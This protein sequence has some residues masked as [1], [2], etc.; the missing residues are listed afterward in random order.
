LR[1]G[2]CA[3]FTIHRSSA[4]CAPGRCWSLPTRT[5]LGRR[6]S[7]G[8]WQWWWTAGGGISRGHR[9]ARIWHPGRDG[10]YRRYPQAVRRPASAH[11]RRSRPGL[12]RGSADDAIRGAGAAG[13]T[14]PC[15]PIQICST[16]TN[17]SQAEWC[18]KIVGLRLHDLR[19]R[20]FPALR[21]HTSIMLT[22]DHYSRSTPTR[23]TWSSPPREASHA[24]VVDGSPTVVPSTC[25]R[26]ARAACADSRWSV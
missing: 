1:R 5:R 7:S 6:S 24:L 13:L 8:S 25:A 26:R 21:R 11:R 18:Q 22:L 9:G 3:S 2:L 23:M 12:L 17:V 15:P 10:N 20:D 16:R 19:T 14:E 4:I